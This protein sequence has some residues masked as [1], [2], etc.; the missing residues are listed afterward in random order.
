MIWPGVSPF[1]GGAGRRRLRWRR[2]RLPW[3]LFRCLWPVSGQAGVGS[4]WG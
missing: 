3:G 2:F 1:R 4:V